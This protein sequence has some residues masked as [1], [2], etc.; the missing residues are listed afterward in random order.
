MIGICLS[1]TC[2]WGRS[3]A[4]GPAAERIIG[5]LIR[6]DRQKGVEYDP[7]QAVN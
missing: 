3:S 1:Q 4:R 5:R 7:V 6:P 2:A